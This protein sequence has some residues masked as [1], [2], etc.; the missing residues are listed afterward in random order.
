MKANGL[1]STSPTNVTLYPLIAAEDTRCGDA[2]MMIDFD[3]T[4]WTTTVR[5]LNETTSE[6][7]LGEQRK[8]TQMNVEENSLTLAL[9]EP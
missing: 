2:F 3:C 5:C 1:C 6:R 8:T 9:C 7:N 4:D